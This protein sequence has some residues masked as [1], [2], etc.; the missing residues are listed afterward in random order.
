MF[1]MSGIGPMFEQIGYFNK[2]AGKEIEGLRPLQ[3]YIS[4]A[5]KLLNVIEGQLVGQDWIVEK[6]SIA[7]IAN[8]PW[9]KGPERYNALDLVGWIHFSK[10]STN[11]KE[12]HSKSLLLVLWGGIAS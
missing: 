2:F 11:R 10:P 7:D 6:L 9:L 4:E 5:K 12:P 3:H 8:G 1:Q